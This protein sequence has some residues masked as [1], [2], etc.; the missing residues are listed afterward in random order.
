MYDLNRSFFIA[1]KSTLAN[2]LYVIIKPNKRTTFPQL[3]VERSVETKRKTK[4]MMMWQTQTQH[5]EL[6]T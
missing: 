4:G 6:K 5:Q 1:Q 3:S 2:T